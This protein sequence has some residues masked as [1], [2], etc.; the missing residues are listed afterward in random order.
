MPSRYDGF[1]GGDYATA[2]AER[3]GLERAIAN[4]G[5]LTIIAAKE[6]IKPDPDQ[7]WHDSAKKLW[8]IASMDEAAELWSSGDWMRLWMLCDSYSAE[9]SNTYADGTPRAPRAQFLEV[10][11][12]QMTELRLSARAK[13][14]DGFLVERG[15]SEPDP[16]VAIGAS[17]EALFED[18][19]DKDAG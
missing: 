4:N 6:V 1:K 3:R 14:A 13:Q 17:V 18:D 8:V 7:D 2:S 11:F 5:H 12:S 15:E 9:Q 10:L 19:S 16:A